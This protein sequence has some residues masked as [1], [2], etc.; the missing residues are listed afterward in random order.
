MTKHPDGAYDSSRQAGA[1]PSVSTGGLS[2]LDAWE[3]SPEGLLAAWK[4]LAA[5]DPSGSDPFETVRQIVAATLPDPLP[6]SLP[7]SK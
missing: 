5:Y 4:V 1:S 7:C 2:A 3:I 6:V